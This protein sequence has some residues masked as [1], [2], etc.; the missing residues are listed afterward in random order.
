ML[1]LIFNMKFVFILEVYNEIL[2]Y[3]MELSTW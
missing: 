3:K 2:Q 1:T